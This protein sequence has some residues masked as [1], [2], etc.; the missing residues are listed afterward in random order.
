MQIEK[1]EAKVKIY[2]EELSGVAERDREIDA[3]L[4]GI[5]QMDNAGL[6][7]SCYSAVKFQFSKR[8]TKQKIIESQMRRI[9]SG[10]KRTRGRR[11]PLALERDLNHLTALHR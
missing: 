2:E 11:T 6:F 5:P 7:S 3:E 9:T 4:A 1:A 10:Q 8:K